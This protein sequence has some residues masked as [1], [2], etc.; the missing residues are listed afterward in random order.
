MSRYIVRNVS[1]SPLTR[2]VRRMSPGRVNRTFRFGSY[3]VGPGRQLEIGEE[4]LLKAIETLI[5]GVKVGA[6]QVLFN[7]TV[8]S[9]S[10]LQTLATNKAAAEAAAS[11]TIE[12]IEDVV[13]T[14]EDTSPEP[15]P[16]EVVEEPDELLDPREAAPLLEEEPEE[17]E[18][19]PVVIPPK[20]KLMKM[21]KKAVVSLLD[22]LD[23]EYDFLSTKKQLVEALLAAN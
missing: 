20:H 14:L 7:T 16:K 6:C 18:R 5:S 3:H 11:V 9:L 22:G 8:L 23:M 21:S 2:T 19:G 13:E 10:A 1:R 15:L 17:V 4:V 12:E